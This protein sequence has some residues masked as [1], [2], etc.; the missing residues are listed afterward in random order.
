MKRPTRILPYVPTPVDPDLIRRW[1]APQPAPVGDGPSVVGWLVRAA[2]DIVPELR[3]VANLRPWD[4]LDA[5]LLA[6][7]EQ[8]RER[9]GTELRGANGR[10]ADIDALQEAVDLA[11]YL[12]QSVI[13]RAGDGGDL[14]RRYRVG[15]AIRMV[16]DLAHELEV[17]P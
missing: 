3:D 12:A 13:D 14:N 17:A 6:R 8:G 15:L 11:I 2:P 5:L 16:L 4:L 10:R 9:Y 7:R 1:L